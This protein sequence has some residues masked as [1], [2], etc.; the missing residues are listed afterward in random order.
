LT[1]KKAYLDNMTVA[2]ARGALM[3]AFTSGSLWVNYVG[4]A[5]VDQLASEGLLTRTDAQSL[6]AT[7]YALPVV[8]ALTCAA[9]SYN[10][11]GYSG[12]GETLIER[13]SA[14]AIAMWA[15]CAMEEDED[16]VLFGSFFAKK[17]FGPSKIV[18]LG[19]GIL[20]A[21]KAAAAAEV[22]VS[23]LRTYNLLGDPGLRIR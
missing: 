23:V 1:V 12:M 8:S 5:G 11:P 2:D 15:P 9:G 20:A 3:A 18:T 4:H 22:P 10:L 16:S 19:Q 7:G 17:V 13:P 21:Q 6:S 14:G